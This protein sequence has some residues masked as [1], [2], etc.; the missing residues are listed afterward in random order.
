M[1][2]TY[3][4][5]YFKTSIKDGTGNPA[6]PP[7]DVYAQLTEL[8]ESGILKG[9]DGLTPYI[10]SNNNWWIGDIDTGVLARGTDGEDGYT[11]VKGV[12]YFTE[13]EV[14][15]IQN[16]VS[17]GAIGDFKAVVD[18]ETAIFNTNAENTL[19][20]Y[21]ANAQEKFDTYNANADSKFE[22]YNTNAETKFS[23]YNTN[24]EAKL[25]EYNKNDLDKTTLYNNNADSKFTTYNTNA[26]TKFS[27]YTNNAKTKLSEYN[28]NDSYKTA[29]YNA[30]AESK[31]G[32][33]DSNAQAKLDLYNENAD[34]RVAEF[35]AQTEQIQTDVSELKSDLTT[36]ANQSEL[37]RTNLSLDALWKMNRGQTWDTLESESEA[38]SVDVPSG[39]HYASVDMVGG[40][41]V[42]WN[43]CW[44]KSVSKEAGITY[45]K[46]NGVYHVVKNTTANNGLTSLYR[47]EPNGHKYYISFA[48]K[49]D[50]ENVELCVSI[51]MAIRLKLTNT[52]QKKS[53]IINT[54]TS[55][56]ARYMIYYYSP[57]GV[58]CEY[59]CTEPIFIDLTQMFGAGNEP[60]VEE[61][62][63]MF[64]DDYYEYCEP[65]IISSQTD[66]IDVMGKNLFD[67]NKLTATDYIDIIDGE[68]RIHSYG[69][70][71]NKTGQKLSDIADL[72]VGETYV[73]KA[74]TTFST[75]H[76]YLNTSMKTW[77]F[78][79]ST[80]ITQE[81][82]DS[83]VGWYGMNAI[84]SN[85]QIEKGSVV[86]EY[87]PYS[88]Q[89]ITTGFPVLNSA[90][91]VYDY[92][93]LNEGKLHQRIGVV[94][95]G[96]LDYSLYSH[97]K[98]GD[99]FYSNIKNLGIKRLGAFSAIKHNILC[100]SYL[101]TTRNVNP[102]SDKC[103]CAD[104]DSEF[105]LQIQI[106]DSSYTDTKSFKQAMS[107]VM[108]YYEL[109]EEIVTDIEIPAELE[110]WLTVEAG[111]SITFHNADDGKRLLIP[112]KLSFVRKLDEVM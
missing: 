38:Y 75:K 59:Y 24:A 92:V 13:E 35:N 65:T 85:I 49:S 78:G 40:K 48:G 62:E 31:F 2:S 9:D 102:F 23:G 50:N 63:A 54:A 57:S 44:G 68:I 111:G 76:I 61:F 6:E 20:G 14:Q 88:L 37:D 87:S 52:M 46:E 10:G 81:D 25:S 91:S 109:A 104:G 28:Q 41:S 107:G 95:M 7:E 103:I 18:E 64:P 105:V 36:K 15:Q 32:A 94:D 55:G 12:D 43:Q 53:E 100:A 11:P 69:N 89:Q 106:K 29:L 98:F 5:V 84:I 51:G 58:E 101:T 74:D 73:L 60:T 96:T 26:E 47:I 77:T 86:T 67:I 19:T 56:N 34:N 83:L 108:L 3:A 45:T 4:D 80:V 33:Y 93:D 97:S 21:N 70:S 17:G 22:T 110:D 8:V 90:G 16:E 71:N 112:N 82:L 27:E 1:T 79:S 99:Y 66:R 42:V 30:N 39:S 72:G